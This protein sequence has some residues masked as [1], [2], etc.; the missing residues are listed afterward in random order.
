MLSLFENC[1]I[2]IRS[3]SAFISQDKYK[4]FFSPYGNACISFKQQNF[5]EAA[6]SLARVSPMH[7]VKYLDYV[8]NFFDLVQM[9]SGVADSRKRDLVVFRG[10]LRDQMPLLEQ[11]CDDETDDDVRYVQDNAPSETCTNAMTMTRNN[12]ENAGTC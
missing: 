12:T 10:M 1:L 4:L 3:I 7:A 9:Q 11:C 8:C 5:A 6:T 2:P